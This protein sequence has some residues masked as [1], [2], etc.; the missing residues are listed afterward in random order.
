[1]T[2]NGNGL[3]FSGKVYNALSYLLDNK[4]IRFGPKLCR[5][6]VGI[7]MGTK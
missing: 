6:I 5:Q 2:G 3:S 1:M 4:C 7:P